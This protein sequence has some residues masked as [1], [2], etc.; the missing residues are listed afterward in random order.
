MRWKIGWG[1]E[2][3]RGQVRRSVRAEERKSIPDTR[4]E[5]KLKIKNQKAKWQMK[6]SK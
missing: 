1:A 3:R 5:E 4:C 6:N 2:G